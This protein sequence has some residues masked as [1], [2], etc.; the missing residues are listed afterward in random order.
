[1]HSIKAFYDH[2]PQTTIVLVL[3]PDYIDQWPE[4]CSEHKFTIPHSIVAGGETRFH[5]VWNALQFIRNDK[6][7]SA[8][9]DPLIAIHD[10][11]RPL[12]TSRII[13]DGYQTALRSGSAIPAVRSTDSVRVIGADET[14]SVIDRNKVVLIQTP[15][16]FRSSVL[17]KAYEQ[18]YDPAFTDDASVIEK[19][20][21]PV[22]IIEG[23]IRNIKVTFP[24]DL[25]IADKLIEQD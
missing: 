21:Y 5:S 3:H 4:I 11:V 2:H 10:G 14:S 18:E 22:H 24:V 9:E 1:M 23:D 8:D 6:V 20:G 13:E 25:V 19:S 17:Q 15:Q 7:F 16:T 12:V